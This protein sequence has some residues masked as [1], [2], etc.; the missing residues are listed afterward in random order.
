MSRKNRYFIYDCTLREGTQS[1]GVALSAKDKLRLVTMLDDMGVSYIEG[2]IP[3]TGPKEEIFYREVAKL[4]LNHS[5]IVPFSP[6]VRKGTEPG[7]DSLLLAIRDLPFDTV[8]VFGKTNPSVVRDVLNAS[9]SEN[10]E[11]IKKTVTFLCDAGKN[12]FFDCEHFF[13]NS[14]DEMNEYGLKC[15]ETAAQSGAKAVILCDT[16]GKALSQDVSYALKAVGKMFS[17]KGI[18]NVRTG[19]HMHNDCGMA[20]AN[21]FYAAG[22]GAEILETTLFGLGERCGNADFFTTVPNLKFRL[23]YDTLLEGKISG[24]TQ[25][26]YKAS[27][28]LNIKARSNAPY[29][30]KNAF[31][32]KAGTH[33][34]AVVKEPSS[35]E[36]VDPSSVGNMRHFIT[37]EITGRTGIRSRLEDITGGKGDAGKTETIL[38]KL[39]QLEYEGYQFESAE[40]SF[41]LLVR[42]MYGIYKPLFRLISYKVITFDEKPDDN[43]SASAIVDLEVDGREEITAGNG[44]GP[45]DA[46]DHA[47]RRA[48][49]HF[50]P[51]ASNIHLVDYKVRVIDSENA[52]ASKVRV[53]IESECDGMRWCTVGVS[54]DI[55]Q[56]SWYALVDSYEYRLLS[57]AEEGNK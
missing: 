35:L 48:L 29:I 39:K 46:L 3:G 37:S 16:T 53:F 32:H 2:G 20:D 7:E 31:S 40:A 44:N 49:G 38:E 8:C 10:L 22:Q 43:Y 5:K 6:T 57:K 23:G 52:T 4:R 42:K 41:E 54:C 50:Y 21:T 18:R 9:L 1:V 24:L 34:N 55:I 25:F 11:L 56:A 15:V 47:F 12:V 13:D 51:E 14:R 26:S 33:I 19:V 27:E 17:A 45:V 28:L 36:S 30:G